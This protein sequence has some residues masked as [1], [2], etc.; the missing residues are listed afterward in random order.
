MTNDQEYREWLVDLKT[1]YQQSRIKAS[2][3][4]NYE[5]IFYYW[6]VG[7]DIVI[8]KAES[9]WGSGF[10]DNLSRDLRRELPGVQGL[11]HTNLRYMR[12]F[13]VLFPDAFGENLISPQLVEKLQQTPWG[14]IRYI[15]DKCRDDQDKAIFFINKTVENNW[16]RAVLL[17]FLDTD[18][19]ERQGKAITNF[20]KSLTLPQGDLAQQLTKD[21]Y[22]FDFLTMRDNYQEKELKDALIANIE[23][24]LLELGKGFAYMGRE[25]R[26]QIGETEK[27]IDMLFYNTVLRCYVVV[28]VKVEKFEAGHLGQLGL[29]VTAVNH[30]LKNETDNPT[31]GL[32]ICKSKENV[33]AKYSLESMAVPIGISEYELQKI[34]PADFKSSLPT[35]EEIESELAGGNNL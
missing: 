22:S 25:Y 31:I 27:F 9:K 6:S 2:I 3:K 24:F 29:Y 26:L 8:K 28:E 20:D 16:S 11:S 17:N 19:Y 4:I 32:L 35:I 21:P 5:V 7:R 15:M 33:V 34:Y 1:R 23:K 10:Y 13:Y 12:N 18:L 30:Q 14:H